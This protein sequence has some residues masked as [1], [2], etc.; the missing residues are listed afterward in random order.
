MSSDD[1]IRGVRGIGVGRY[2]V[3][4]VATVPGG[5]RGIAVFLCGHVGGGRY[6]ITMISFLYN[7]IDLDY[8]TN[9]LAFVLANGGPALGNTP[10]V[11]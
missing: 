11:P 1:R 3:C 7:F 4:R 6:S 5:V 10:G 8:F 2:A 9:S